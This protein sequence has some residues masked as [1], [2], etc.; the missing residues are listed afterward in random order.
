MSVLEEYQVNDGQR[1]VGP[2]S[3]GGGGELEPETLLGLFEA[4]PGEVLRSVPGRTTFLY[5]ASGCTSFPLVVKRFAAREARDDWYERLR[6][7]AVRSQGQREYDNLR[8][9]AADGIRVP[10]ALAWARIGQRSLVVMERIKAERSAREVLAGGAGQERTRLLEQVLDLTVRLHDA[11]WYHRDLYLQHVLAAR[12]RSGEGVESVLIDV[13]RARRVGGG[14]PRRRW[15]EKDLA[16]LMHSSRD[17]LTDTERGELLQAY[18][19][20]RGLQPDGWAEAVERRRRKMARHVP[21]FGEGPDPRPGGAGV[22]RS[23]GAEP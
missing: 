6:G 5:G 12:D 17:C 16:A 23:Q 14:G 7:R 18:L 21:R 9:L 8:G 22:A 10:R 13:G 15:F 11:G 19:L 20:R 2:D 3:P 1:G 4:S